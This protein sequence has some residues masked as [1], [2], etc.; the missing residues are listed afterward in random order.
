MQLNKDYEGRDMSEDVEN[1][2]PNIEEPASIET[3]AVSSAP[4]NNDVLETADLGDEEDFFN[5]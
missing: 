5:I 2:Q 4:K 3:P 1:L